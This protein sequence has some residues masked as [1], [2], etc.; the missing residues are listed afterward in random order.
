VQASG[1]EAQQAKLRITHLEKELS[2]KRTL[3]AAKQKEATSMEKELETV[4]AAVDK[5]RATL[6]DLHFDES[7][8]EELKTVRD[9]LNFHERSPLALWTYQASSQS[10]CMR[11]CY[12]F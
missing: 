3:L 1:A 8:V 5:W 9:F 6:D 11:L 4:T 2:S 10:M 7:R 12:P